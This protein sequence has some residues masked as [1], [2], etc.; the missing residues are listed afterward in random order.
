MYRAFL[1]ALHDFYYGEGHD[2]DMREKYAADRKKENF[3]D[4][5]KIAIG[6]FC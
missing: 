3:R 2:D 4:C 1:N 5:R 6:R